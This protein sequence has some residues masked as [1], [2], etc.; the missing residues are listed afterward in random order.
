M[1]KDVPIGKYTIKAV[2]AGEKLLLNNRRSDDNNEESKTV[3]FG[4]YGYLGETEYNT[5]FYI[6][7]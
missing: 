6:T 5:E 2:Y 3:I 1:V 7:K 4:K